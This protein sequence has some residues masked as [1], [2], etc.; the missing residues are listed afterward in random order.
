MT[1]TDTVNVVY[2]S[3]QLL[4]IL[5]GMRLLK[6]LILN[7]DLKKL[8]TLSKLH[9]KEEVIISFNYFIELNHIWVVHLLEYFDL[10]RYPI[11]ILFFLDLRLL[12][13]LN[14]NLLLLHLIRYL[15]SPL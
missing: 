4:E 13:D 8:T 9:H 14:R 15:P 6:P 5:A 3:H 12:Q 10:S 1:D 11:Y 7:Y 2:R